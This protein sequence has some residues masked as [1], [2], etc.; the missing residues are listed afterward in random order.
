MGRLLVGGVKHMDDA[1]GASIEEAAV[2]IPVVG[3]SYW[4]VL[5]ALGS[6]PSP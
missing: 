4:E 6:Q 3:S 2:H 5:R 1:V